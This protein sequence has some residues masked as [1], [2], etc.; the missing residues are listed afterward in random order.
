[1]IYKV[2]LESP[3]I[4]DAREYAAYIKDVRLDASAAQRWLLQLQVAIECLSELPK[5]FRVIEEQSEFSIEL[6][7]FVHYSHRVI[8]YVNDSTSTVHVLRIY[9]ASRDELKGSDLDFVQ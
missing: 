2:V 1:L 7:Q 9:H 4:L 8:Y 5:R 6:R 3:A